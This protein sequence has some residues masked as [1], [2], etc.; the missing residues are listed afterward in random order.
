MKE[1]LPRV[2]MIIEEINR[3]F[4]EKLREAY[5]DKPEKLQKMSILWDKKVRMANLAIVGSHSVNGVAALHT[6][7]LKKQ[8]LKDFNEYF[9][10]KFN[11]KT[12]GITHR[13]WLIS[14]NPGLSK[15]ICEAIGDKWIKEPNALEDLL[16]FANDKEFCEA[17]AA[18]KH[19]KKI[20]MDK[21]VQEQ[22]GF[23]L[24]KH[25]M[26]CSQVKRLHAY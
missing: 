25:S 18:I 19:E 14:A 5:P 22:F 4:D 8:E 2:Y 3:R 6:E 21:F 20:E 12:N 9:P 13:R 10:G 7:I 26:F 1:L 11:N 23:H 17:V 24:D 15:L 16:P